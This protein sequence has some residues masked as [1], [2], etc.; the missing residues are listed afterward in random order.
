MTA[1]EPDRVTRLGD[2]V[3]PPMLGLTPCFGSSQLCL[4][5]PENP[6]PLSP[7]TAATRGMD[8]L[9]PDRPQLL[10]CYDVHGVLG[11]LTREHAASLADAFRRAG[12]AVGC[13]IVSFQRRDDH[14]PTSND[15]NAAYYP[16]ADLALLCVFP[17]ERPEELNNNRRPALGRAPK[18][19]KRDGMPAKFWVFQGCKRALL[20]SARC[21]CHLFGDKIENLPDNHPST[22]IPRGMCHP[23][24]YV[25]LAEGTQA[26]IARL[27]GNASRLASSV[28]GRAE[29]QGAGN[30]R[31]DVDTEAVW[32]AHFDFAVGV[33]YSNP[34]DCREHFVPTRDSGQWELYRTDEGSGASSRWYYNQTRRIWMWAHLLDRP[35][36]HIEIRRRFPECRQA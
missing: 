25:L 16:I 33:W 12:P 6:G 9:L 26:A 13:A 4:H 29:G 24:I 27:S 2:T 31:Q 5:G 22:L 35:E 32:T 19:A 7:A 15:A 18:L 21:C 36:G 14:W 8:A 20:E 1:E 11:E 30:C 3:F 17:N 23:N 10:L 34:R 28:D